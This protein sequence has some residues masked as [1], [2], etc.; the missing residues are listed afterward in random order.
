MGELN[1]RYFKNCILPKKYN[2][3]GLSVVVWKVGS[4]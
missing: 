3:V 2:A 4:V 1:K